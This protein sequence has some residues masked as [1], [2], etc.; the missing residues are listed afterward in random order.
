[1]NA[2]NTR[3]THDYSPLIEGTKPYKQ[4]VSARSEML[5]NLSE[6][7]VRPGKKVR[8]TFGA[9]VVQRYNEIMKAHRADMAAGDLAF[10]R[11][12]FG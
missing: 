3:R 11:I 8:K 4:A 6:R 10:K 2:D 7:S 1:M 5:H 9:T 12:A